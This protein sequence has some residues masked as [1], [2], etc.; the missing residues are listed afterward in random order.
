MPGGDENPFVDGDSADVLG[1]Y[2]QSVNLSGGEDNEN[3][4]RGE[5]E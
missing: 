2:E 4:E 1:V 3:V 5:A